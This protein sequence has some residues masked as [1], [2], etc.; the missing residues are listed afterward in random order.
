MENQALGKGVSC[1][2]NIEDFGHH[3]GAVSTFV[4]D[5]QGQTKGCRIDFK[6]VKYPVIEGERNSS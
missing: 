6:E 1:S 2:E 3:G 4:L 5:S